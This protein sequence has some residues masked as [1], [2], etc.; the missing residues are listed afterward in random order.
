MIA[1]LATAVE[2]KRVCFSGPMRQHVIVGASSRVAGS[3]GAIVASGTEPLPD[4]RFR[5]LNRI[6]RARVVRIAPGLAIYH[7]PPL[8]GI[9][10]V[11]EDLDHQAQLRTQRALII[12]EPP[13]P[14]LVRAITATDGS[15][16]RAV[17]AE[18]GE[19]V[20]EHALIVIVSRVERDHTVALSWAAVS[21]GS[22]EPMVL[23]HTP[24]GCDATVDTWVEPRAG[25]RVVLSWVDDAGRISEPSKPIVISGASKGK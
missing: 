8:A 6:V 9:D 24:Y 15:G 17:N 12:E 5:D 14:P 1:V 23:W 22:S 3:G 11:L 10:V 16:R 25:E 7:P 19:P 13:A 21:G 18:L 2:A 4:W 20:P